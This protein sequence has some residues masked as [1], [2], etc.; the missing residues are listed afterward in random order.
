MMLDT[1]T[2]RVA[3]GVV[4]LTLLLLFYFITFR[5]TRSAYSAWWC[6]ALVLFLTGSAAYLLDGTVHQVWANPLGNSVLVTGAASVWA[7]A[8]SL[9]TARPRA[10]QLGAGPAITVAASV[11]DNPA[12]NDWSGG[13]VFLALMGLMIALASRE[14]W[15][16]KPGYSRVQ[17]PM[18]AA[19]GLL[20]AYYF[21]R[22]AA[23]MAEG[24]HGPVF[25]AYFGS[26]PTALATTA[27]LVVVS[28][29]M[30]VL[31]NEQQTHDLRTRA[32]YD[33]LTGLLNRTAFLHL[34]LN[35]LLRLRRTKTTASLILADLDHFKTVNDEYG[36]A[37]GD[38]ALQAFAAACTGS[39]RSTDLI[40][41][42]GGE[43]FILLLPGADPH[44]AG[45]I[46]AEISRLLLASQDPGGPRL[47]TVSYG[48]SSSGPGRADLQGMISTAD[49]ALYQAKSL[50]RNRVVLASA[51]PHETP[52]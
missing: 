27:L 33:G 35:E 5:H 34:A 7:G 28:F 11:V 12:S 43:E 24:P 13:P 32:T 16:L 44:R 29:S 51:L 23:F 22:W 48:I 30:A 31:S 46:A 3:S 47:P 49:A 26:P 18:A 36:H 25:V 1:G 45:Q 38:T 50:G 42:Y 2:L 37:A 15:L 8:R 52:S 41:R 6:A 10:W 40:G 4:T 20:A 39:A 21:G 14:L 9:R 19:S 17:R